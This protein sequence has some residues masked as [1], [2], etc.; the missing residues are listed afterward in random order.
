MDDR[1][2][3]SGAGAGRPTPGEQDFLGVS[4]LDRRSLG[5][6]MVQGSIW[7]VAW[8]W[9]VRGI[10]LVSTVILARLLTPAD[11]GLVAM[12]MLVVGVIEVFAQTGVTLALI[13]IPS[14]TR[15]HFDTAW[16]LQ[17]LINTALAV[18]MV[19]AAP[20]SAL[21]FHD[22]RVENLVYFLSLRTFL[23]GFINM[24][25]VAF[26]INLDFAKDFWLGVLQK[27]ATFIIG[28]TLA[29]LLR[30]YW[31]LAISIVS[32]QAV[33]IILSYAMHPYRPRIDFSKTREIWSYSIWMLSVYVSDY[34]SNRS[35]EFIVGAFA[36]TSQMGYYNVGSDVASS[37]V[38]ELIFPIARALFPVYAKIAGDASRLRQVVLDVL[39]NI[40]TLCLS[41]GVGV[42]LIARD[43]AAVVLGPQWGAAATIIQWLALGSAASG[44]M[45]FIFT[46]LNVT[47]NVRRSS[48]LSWTRTIVLI[49]CMVLA[50]L[51]GGIYGVALV[52]AAVLIALVP[53]GFV[54]LRRTIDISVGQIAART[55]RPFVAAAAMSAGM[56]FLPLD[57][58]GDLYLRLATEI[59]VGAVI[60]LAVMLLAWRLIGCP[61]GLEMILTKFVAQTWG[62]LFVSPAVTPASAGAAR[63][64]SAIVLI[65]GMPRSGTTWLAKAFD[66]HPDVVYRHEP[67]LLLSGEGLPFLCRREDYE[68]RA[69]LA[70][71]YLR[72]LAGLS[73]ASTMGKLPVFRK[74]FH[75][76][77]KHFF[78]LLWITLLRA[79]DWLSWGSRAARSLPVPDF[80][81]SQSHPVVIKSI[82]MLGRVGL[83][84]RAAPDVR[85]ILIVRHPCDQ[86]AS[87]LRGLKLKKFRYREPAS[88]I[89]ETEQAKRRG[90]TLERFLAQPLIE[91]LAW[92]WVMATPV[93]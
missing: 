48:A 29:V 44:I 6:H 37:P 93:V 28:V 42:A 31:A 5:S 80:T 84:A 8:R 88:M 83:L 91:Q 63:G 18:V 22:A 53:V 40:A 62:F 76:P 47:G 10:G 34:F 52:R 89:V 87:Q 27:L 24:G 30:S 20:L 86:I 32:A 70:A 16:T 21:Y 9:T 39:G 73:S 41:I 36:G 17:V 64:K 72:R 38:N 65:V 2:S 79:A 57:A 51:W 54:M 25:I 14:P 1:V 78:R 46:V 67:D 33:A 90:L 45:E 59:L 50:A 74:R 58:I 15:A 69:P 13:R 85:T 3:S 60:F 82:I 49:P 56:M 71:G 77:T 92:Q 35:D 4:L 23:S 12:A 7:N 55:W 81:D 61:E 19:L 11:F 75:S 26:R 66:S 68:R 43:Y